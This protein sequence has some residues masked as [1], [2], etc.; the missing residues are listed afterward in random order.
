[1]ALPLR[2]TCWQRVEFVSRTKMPV[3]RSRRHTAYRAALFMLLC[4]CQA[5]SKHSVGEARGD[6]A[7]SGVICPHAALRGTHSRRADSRARCEMRVRSVPQCRATLSR[8]MRRCYS[9]AEEEGR[10]HWCYAMLMYSYRLNI[11][12]SQRSRYALGEPSNIDA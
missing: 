9:T 5:R 3:S 7:M 1:M 8:G 2:P 10:N 4:R 11:G 6:A 12:R